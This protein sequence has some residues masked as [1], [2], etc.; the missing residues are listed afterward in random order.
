MSIL[1][2]LCTLVAVAAVPG[3]VGSIAKQCD[4]DNK[5][6][7]KIVLGTKLDFELAANQAK[8]EVRTLENSIIALRIN[9]N[10][11][12]NLAKARFVRLR[13]DIIDKKC[14]KQHKVFAQMN[15]TLESCALRCKKTPGC[16]FISVKQHNTWCIGCAG[17]PTKK[18]LLTKTYQLGKRNFF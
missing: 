3:P 2:A 5:C 14:A 15:A 18:C 8:R 17:K 4:N 12:V 10:R 13:D 1:F 11:L 7:A 6:G 16:E 9:V